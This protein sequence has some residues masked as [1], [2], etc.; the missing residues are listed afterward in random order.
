MPLAF[1][2]LLFLFFLV[3]AIQNS[4]FGQITENQAREMLAEKGISEDTLRYRLLQKG[5]DPERLRP[6]QIDEFQ[7]VLA[8]TIREIESDRTMPERNQ[9]QPAT[10]P[11]ESSVIPEKNNP[12][13]ITKI[14]EAATSDPDKL[15]IYGQQ[16]FRD[17][18]LAVFQQS[19]E[20]SPSDTYIIGTGDKLGVVGFGRSQFGHIME[21]GADGFI[22]PSD[23]LPRILVKGLT[24]GE[25]KELLYQRYNQYYVIARGEFQV[26]INKPRNITV[27]VFGEAL[28]TG[29]FAV[30]GFNTAFNVISAAGGPTDIG[31]V[32]K[33][34]VISG[35]NVRLL[36][37]YEFMNNPEVAKDFY[38]QDNDYIHI[39]VV[40]KVVSIIG[41]VNRPMSYELLDKENLS[42]LIKYAGGLKADGYLSD[43][44]VIRFLEDRRI[45]TNINFKELSDGGGD[46]ILYNGDAI[47]IK[48][49]EDN[50]LNFVNV[51]GAVQFPGRYER[52][53]EMK[54]SDVID[55][56]ILKPE[57]R[58]DFAYV[59]RYQPD[60]T[61]QYQRINL[62]EIIDNPASPQNLALNNGDEI[63]ILTL[64]TY[65]DLS[66][67]TVTGAVR[68]PDTFDFNPHGNLKL[69]DAI[70][71]GGGLSIDA[72]DHGYIIRFDPAEPKTVEYVH[73]DLREAF[74]NPSSDANVMIEAG[75]QVV[76][77]DKA[78]LRDNLNVSI[79]GAVRNPGTFA[80]G[81][82]M[83]L[84]DVINLAGGFTFSA[85]R[86]RIDIARSEFGNG[87]DLKIT[88]YT[89]SLPADFNLSQDEDKSLELQPYDHIYVREI[90]EFE[91]QQ[92]V[93]LSGEVKYPGTYAI[94]QANERISD[95][96]ARAGGLTEEAFSNGAKMYRQGD[97]TGLVVINLNEILQ[98]ESIPSNVTLLN[99]DLITIPK[100]RDLVTIGGNVN[101]DDAYSEGFLRNENSISVAFRGNKSAKYYIDNFAAGI[102]EKG[103]P[104]EVKVQF[105]DGRV[106]KS[107]KFL[108]FNSYPKVERGAIITVGDKEVKPQVERENK[109][110]DWGSVLRDTLTQATAVLTILILVDQL[111][112]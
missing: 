15:P 8:E 107:E 40:E 12:S 22:K 2:H 105:A 87:Q 39:P 18:S 53:N 96:I 11:I 3:T 6:D 110:V 20:I 104:T 71:L 83:T 14:T 33:I 7:A 54:I 25:V 57:A 10:P 68:E 64:K 37:V 59:L 34:K 16:I 93:T 78:S 1:R 27:N 66:F 85:D 108:F 94:L 55:Q 60:G 26:T 41:A 111:N 51:K 29:A 62:R 38:L 24:L 32:R 101:L 100:N 86:D 9:N 13:G 97:S 48:S 88:Q 76:V 90:P 45:V 75:D 5:Y 81:S 106:E 58:L 47:A 43:V 92:T 82:G 28:T 69:E 56:S 44:Q 84:A 65:S 23:N 109:E 31:S 42:H 36:D 91:L 77:Y 46:Y 73:I 102:S 95:I 99:G 70:L 17:N 19:E 80:Y 50:A 98:N 72:A 103:A 30:P 49:I 74:N 4:A 21:V 61:Y 35:K 79:F 63:Q 89:A 52:R 112:K 67:F